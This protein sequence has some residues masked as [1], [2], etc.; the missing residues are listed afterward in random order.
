MLTKLKGFYNHVIIQ[1]SFTSNRFSL[2][3]ILMFVSLIGRILF[4]SFPEENFLI[5]SFLAILFGFSWVHRNGFI[6]FVLNSR[7]FQYM[8]FLTIEQEDELYIYPGVKG[9]LFAV[10]YFFSLLN[11][12]AAILYFLGFQ[13][14]Y[15]YFF[16]FFYLMSYW[17]LKTFFVCPSRESIIELNLDGSL[18]LIKNPNEYN[19]EFVVK[20]MDCVA[21]KWV[22]VKVNNRVS[23]FFSKDPLPNV[24]ARFMTT[25]DIKSDMLNEFISISKKHPRATLGAA[26][27][28][29]ITASVGIWAFIDL[30]KYKVDAMANATLNQEKIKGE[31]AF[32]I[33]K[34]QEDAETARLKLSIEA[35][36]Q[37]RK[38]ELL[39]PSWWRPSFLDRIRAGGS[40]PKVVD[41]D[42]QLKATSIY[43]EP[44]IFSMVIK[45]FNYCLEF[46]F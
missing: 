32:A 11:G 3:L 8:L 45:K 29:G 1:L 28:L 18:E 26:S 23:P 7:L 4:F 17:K 35:E 30:E 14:Y 20:I 43:E 15:W 38:E 24:G 36:R 6:E 19:W 46:I 9:D 33:A 41:K 21:Q 25:G 31:N 40:E 34:Y 44:G 12:P 27:A 16:L 39:K 42:S 13:F 37:L 5:Y 2:S 10:F 22:R